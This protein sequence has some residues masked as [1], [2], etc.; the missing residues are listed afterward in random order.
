MKK[1]IPAILLALAAAVLCA[2]LISAK[3]E[4][5]QLKKS[6][7]ARQEDPPQRTL[8]ASADIDAVNAETVSALSSDRPARDP[9]SAETDPE[10]SPRQRIMSD[11][12]RAIEENPTVN[13]MVE[14]SQRGAIGA[15]YA[16]MIE[17]MLKHYYKTTARYSTSSFMRLKMQ[18]AL[19][20][21]GLQPHIFE[22]AEEAHA[23]LETTRAAAE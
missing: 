15:L 22:R 9:V 6:L 8:N 1:Q 17:Y 20:K 11:M 12:A 13:K 4:I 16:D 18:E 14:A 23:A 7:A 19:S 3:R 21:R 10:Q 5:R 2:A